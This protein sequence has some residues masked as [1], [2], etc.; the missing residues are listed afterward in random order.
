[1]RNVIKIGK[2]GF[3][4]RWLLYPGTSTC[5]CAYVHVCM[6]MYIYV[7]IC[8]CMCAYVHVSVHMYIRG[9][10]RGGD[11]VTCQYLIFPWNYSSH[12][13]RRAGTPTSRYSHFPIY[14]IPYIH[15]SFQHPHFIHVDLNLQTTITN[16]FL[17]L[18]NA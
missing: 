16:H 3:H 8:I 1:M 6:H 9:G 2:Y 15:T 13:P 7:C 17:L 11:V 18:I 12:D 4:E 5:M 10:S 14:T